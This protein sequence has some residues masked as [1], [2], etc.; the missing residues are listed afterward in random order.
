MVFPDLPD[1][2]T[3]PFDYDA[4]NAV[5]LRDMAGLAVIPRAAGTLRQAESPIGIRAYARPGRRRTI[6]SRRRLP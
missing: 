1:G 4:D 2:A 6:Y 5:D 3:P